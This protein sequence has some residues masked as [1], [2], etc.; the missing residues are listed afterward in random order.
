MSKKGNGNQFQQCSHQ[1]KNS[2][3]VD[4]EYFVKSS[5]KAIVLPYSFFFEEKT[6]L[7]IIGLQK[8]RKHDPNY[9]LQHL[10]LPEKQSHIL[11][12][13]KLRDFKINAALLSAFEREKENST[14]SRVNC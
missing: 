1:M 5:F 7:L 9:C 10:Y 3:N 6:Y 11:H 12:Q 14:T 2:G 13:R 4:K 8:K